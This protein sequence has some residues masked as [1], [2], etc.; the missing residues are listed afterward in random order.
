[1]PDIEGEIKPFDNPRDWEK[2]NRWSKQHQEALIVSF[3]L[4][5]DQ[6][7]AIVK[8]LWPG[9]SLLGATCG[10]GFAISTAEEVAAINEILA[11]DIRIGLDQEKHEWM[12]QTWPE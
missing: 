6:G 11:P 3:L 7:H 2:L 4:S 8:R 12:L 9:E 5:E 1:M 10:K